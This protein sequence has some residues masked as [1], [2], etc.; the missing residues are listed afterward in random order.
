MSPVLKWLWLILCL[1][2]LLFLDL[3]FLLSSLILELIRIFNLLDIFIIVGCFISIWCM[4]FHCCYNFFVI[5]CSIETRI[6]T[7]WTILYWSVWETRIEVAC[8]LSQ[9]GFLKIR[10]IHF[11]FFINFFLAYLLCKMRRLL[12]LVTIKI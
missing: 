8:L 3:F 6:C 10:K 9:I 7:K 12:I 11:H 5:F 4:L 2:N 1:I